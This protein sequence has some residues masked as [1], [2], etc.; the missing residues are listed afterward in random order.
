LGLHVVD[1]GVTWIICIVILNEI[2]RQVFM[3]LIK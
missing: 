1:D 3:V 2:L